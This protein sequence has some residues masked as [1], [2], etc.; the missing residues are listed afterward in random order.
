M[1][2][3]NHRAPAGAAE[4]TRAAGILAARKKDEEKKKIPIHKVVFEMVKTKKKEFRCQHTFGVKSPAGYT[5]VPAGTPDLTERCKELCMREDLLAYLVSDKPTRDA[6]R[7][8]TRIAYYV[9]RVGFHF[10]SRVVDMACE[11]HGYVTH[12]NG[13]Y[14][15][16]RDRNECNWIARSLKQHGK[17]IGNGRDLT[18]QETKDQIK[19]AMLDLFPKIPDEDMKEVIRR[20]FGQDEATVGNSEESLPRRVQLAVGA[21]IRHQYTDYDKLLRQS[22]RRPVARQIVEEI[23]VK[24]MVNW[25]GEDPEQMEEVFREVIILDDDDEEDGDRHVNNQNSRSEGDEEDDEIEITLSEAGPQDLLPYQ[26]DTM[27]AHQFETRRTAR[28]HEPAYVVRP[29]ASRNGSNLPA[30][31]LPRTALQTSID[32]D[33]RRPRFES[34]PEQLVVAGTAR[35]R[36]SDHRPGRLPAAE[37]NR[38]YLP[39][40][41]RPTA[42]SLISP[43]QNAPM[44][45]RDAHGRLFNLQPVEDEPFEPIPVRSNAV[46]HRDPLYAAP[47][48]VHVRL[49]P[50]RVRTHAEAG[51][52]QLPHMTDMH[53]PL[54]RDAHLRLPRTV[55]HEHDRPIPSI[56]RDMA[57]LDYGFT[58][59][60]VTPTHDEARYNLRNR[61]RPPPIASRFGIPG[62]LSQNSIDAS[63]GIAAKGHGLSQASK[64]QDLRHQ[65]VKHSWA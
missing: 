44:Q 60:K 29:T 45:G 2:R 5:Y 57:P 9:H 51:G 63:V 19:A 65:V 8:P 46:R 55:D 7:D 41:N 27:N 16:P 61:V 11:Y 34:R 13:G 40:T 6:Q 3:L 26:R 30:F 64:R 47:N 23:C 54:P 35:M 56:E 37:P 12:P 10:P 39:A 48:P 50:Q 38:G 4:G 20:A 49:D 21:H 22:V 32:Q 36:L 18:L 62:N 43:R 14:F 53:T 31:S 42:P 58:H 28:A 1:T 15:R 25:R 59:P 33:H 17:R 52:Q 24:I